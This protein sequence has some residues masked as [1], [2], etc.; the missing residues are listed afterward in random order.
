MRPYDGERRKSEQ[1][2][3]M[4]DNIAPSY[5][6]MNTL[7]TFG[8]YRR[9]RDKAL[10]EAY[11]AL[12]NPDSAHRIIDLAT[13]T[14]DLAFELASR[15]PLAEVRGVDLSENM[16]AQARQKADRLR[17]AGAV[18]GVD[19]IVFESGDCLDLKYPD[20]T[21]DLLTIAYGV[22]NFEDLAKGFREFYRIL[23]PGGICMI[24]EL[25]RPEN[26]FL[27]WGYDIYSGKMIP[28]IGR[29]V[30]KDS[31]AYSYLPESIKAM[32]PRSVIAGMLKNTGFSKVEYR[33]LCMGVVTYYIAKK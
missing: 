19:N 28:A 2:E 30:S 23:R 21:F 13:G 20:D 3:E 18:K 27:Q 12:K 33:S 22:R 26:G 17:E 11:K 5:D 25:S 29:M 6:L 14:G 4:F 16:L 32:P 1:V 24:L 9:W 8:M 31:R 15:Y 7:M 10:G